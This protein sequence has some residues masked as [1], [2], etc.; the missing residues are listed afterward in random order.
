[1][2]STFSAWTAWATE[3]CYFLFLQLVCLKE[4]LFDYIQ[5]L[6]PSCPIFFSE[7]RYLWI[8]LK[9]SASLI[10]IEIIKKTQKL[11]RI[12]WKRSETKID[13]ISTKL[14]SSSQILRSSSNPINITRLIVSVVNEFKA[15]GDFTLS[16]LGRLWFYF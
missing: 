1:M 4:R 6:Y 7:I 10:F 13:T 2:D 15:H 12:P 11:P 3:V 8:F 14:L 9:R 16:I 5:T